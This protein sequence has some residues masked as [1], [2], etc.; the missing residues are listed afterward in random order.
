MSN[1]KNQTLFQFIQSNQVQAIITATGLLG[2]IFNFYLVSKLA[3]IASSIDSLEARADHTDAELIEFV[4]RA[5]LEATFRPIQEDIQE[6]KQD[7][8]D[9]KNLLTQ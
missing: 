6:I 1:D 9:I 5:E 3:P 8:R 4:P 7:V 2:V